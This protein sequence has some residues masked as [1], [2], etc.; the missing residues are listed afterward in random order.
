MDTSRKKSSNPPILRWCL[1]C[2][3]TVKTLKLPLSARQQ[4]ATRDQRQQPSSE[5]GRGLLRRGNDSGEWEAAAVRA[6]KHWRRELW[7]TLADGKTRRDHPLGGLIACKLSSFRKPSTPP[8]NSNTIIHRDWDN[9]L[10]THSG[11]Q[12]TPWKQSNL[13]KEEPL[14]WLTLLVRPYTE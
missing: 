6:L 7:E 9:N 13:E 10:K 2:Q 4:D 3:E 8:Q 12:K 14:S 1:R 11:A 5:P